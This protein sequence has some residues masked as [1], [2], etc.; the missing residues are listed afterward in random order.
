MSQHESQRLTYVANDERSRR[1]ATL[2]C[3]PALLLALLAG[4]YLLVQLLTAP[5][6]GDAP[7]NLHWGLLTAEQPR[8]LLDAVDPYERIKGFPPDPQSLAPLGLYRNQPSALHPWWGPVA[9]LLFA[10]V[11]SLTHSYLLLQLVVPLAGAGAVLLTYAMARDL[12][13]PRKALIAAAFLACFPLFR[14]YAS[15]AYT[16]ALSTLALTAALLAYLRGRTLLTVLLGAVA[17]LSKMDLLVLYFGVVGA[18]AAYALFRRDRTLPPAHHAAALIGPAVLASPWVWVHYLHGGAG[19]P[20][21]GPSL[22]LFGIIAP[23]ML[24]LLFYIPWYGALITLGALGVCLAAALRGRGAAPLAMVFLGSW[25]A[26]GLAV[27]LVYAATPGAG[28]SP[29]VIMPALPPLALLFADGFT[30]LGVAW[31]RRIGFYL[32]V[33]FA[34]IN[35]AVIGYYAVQGATLRSYAPVWEALRGQPRGF[36]LTEKYWETI[37]YTRQPATWFEAD[38]TFQRN[39]MQNGEHFKRYVEQNPIRYIVLPAQP[40]QLAAR[41]VYSYLDAHA[42]RTLAGAYIV[43][44]LF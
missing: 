17:A 6:Y 32:V 30:R 7:R 1:L 34:L 44:R 42:H 5:I 12:Y 31:R 13:G 40:G 21:H 9:P 4:Q 16:E 25:L 18:C 35:I 20:V 29:R 19:G 10:L 39:I 24:G 11:W 27:L 2:L 15:S 41:D 22:E 38:E 26:L 43:Y 36:V 37:L 28:N 8:F 14:D 3:S 23:Q 33:L